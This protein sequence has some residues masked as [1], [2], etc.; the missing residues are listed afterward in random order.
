MTTTRP[1]DI[2]THG[3]TAGPRCSSRVTPESPSDPLSLRERVRVRAPHEPNPPE[4]N[5][6]GP[7]RSSLHRL[8]LDLPRPSKTNHPQPLIPRKT[9]GFRPIRPSEKISPTTVRRPTKTLPPTFEPR[10]RSRTPSNR[11]ERARTVS[12]VKTCS[13]TDKTSPKL[14][15]T[16][17][18]QSPIPSETLE[19]LPVWP[20]GINSPARH[21]VSEKSSSPEHRRPNRARRRILRI[22]TAMRS[23]NDD[24]HQ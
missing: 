19:I 12:P 4:H 8:G 9:L 18:P 10:A 23:G 3:S 2:L 24:H 6:T 20:R 22:G 21:P 16:D 1:L 17:H 11:S 7:N 13:Q 15:K 5:R 14:S